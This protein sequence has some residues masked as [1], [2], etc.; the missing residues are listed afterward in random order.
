MRPY[1]AIIKDSFRA[2]LASRVLY[3]LLGLIT[4]LLIVLV[5]FHVREVL[6]W[7][8]QFGEHVRNPEVL[9]SQIMERKDDA[10]RPEVARVWNM[11]SKSVQDQVKDVFERSQGTSESTEREPPGQRMGKYGQILEELNTIIKQPE[12]YRPEDWEDRIVGAEAEALIEAGPRSLNEER[13]R[14]LNRLLMASAF[15]GAIQAGSP[16]SLDFYYGIW[17]WDWISASAT[18]QQFESWLN[19]AIPYIFDKFVLSI[20]LFVAILVTANIMPETFE[21]GSL[22]LLL[23]KP[24]SR[25]GL[26][27]SKFIGGCA[28]VALCSV[29]LF[30]GT[31]LWLGIGLGV[32]DRAFLWS[33]PLYI[34]V[35][36][37]YYSVSSLIGLSYRSTIMAIVVTGLFWAFCFGVGSGYGFLNAKMQNAR[38][39]AATPIKDRLVSVNNVGRVFAWQSGAR[40]W[41]EAAEGELQPEE[42]IAEGFAVWMDELRDEPLRLPPRFDARSNRVYV[43]VSSV[44]NPLSRNNQDFMVADAETLDFEKVGKFP[45]DAMSFFT[46]P[47]GLLMVTSEGRFLE[48]D[49]DDIPDAG[50]EAAAND[51]ALDRDTRPQAADSDEPDSKSEEDAAA[52]TGETN[53]PTKSKA[54]S[55]PTIADLVQRVGPETPVFVRDSTSVAYNQIRHELAIFSYR[56]GKHMIYTYERDGD[57]YR[58]RGALELDTGSSERMRCRIEYQGNTILVVVGNGQVITIDAQSMQEQ[59]GYLPESSFAI[60]SVNASPDGRWFALHYRHQVIWLLDTQNAGK[61][62]KP[63]V[64]GQG[65]ISA[66]GFDEEN[67]MWVADRTDRVTCYDPA[68]MTRTENFTPVGGLIENTYRYVAKPFYTICPKPSE[69]YKVVTH[70]SDISDTKKNAEIDLTRTPKKSNPFAPLWSGLGFMAVMLVLACMIF[71]FKD[72]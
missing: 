7:K 32:W 4:L 9:V 2:A 58:R 34:L 72:Y 19:I 71:H 1:F 23:S 69:F 25:W 26:Y 44:V 21:P 5:P 67:R 11:M 22:N 46:T 65:T 15:P 12:F 20:G 56:N 45:K 57:Q 38:L 50:I 63:N 52:P 49:Y 59:Q 60:E 35:F 37:I 54:G 48:L 27:I 42:K 66:V 41:E 36:M 29:Y 17:K 70:L 62:T 53:R 47:E 3:V 33:I 40:K 61:I 28:F 30:L 13:S 14:R 55:Q 39:I 24:I 64:Q 51:E 8:L 10:N 16:T 43:G 18:R 68:T 6:D 31:W